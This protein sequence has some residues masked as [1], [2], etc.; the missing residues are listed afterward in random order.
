MWLKKYE[1]V[2]NQFFFLLGLKILPFK[3]LAVHVIPSGRNDI[4]GL[5]RKLN[6]KMRKYRHALLSN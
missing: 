5:K 2:D 6:T 1:G 4:R 3:F